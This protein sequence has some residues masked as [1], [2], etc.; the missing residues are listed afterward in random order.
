[1]SDPILFRYADY[2]DYYVSNRDNPQLFRNSPDVVAFVYT[3]KKTD[4]SGLFRLI[5][6]ITPNMNVVRQYIGDFPSYP[7]GVYLI[8]ETAQNPTKRLFWMTP[9]PLLN[10]YKSATTGRIERAEAVVVGNHFTFLLE[11]EG[12]NPVK[13]HKT[14]YY[15]NLDNKGARTQTNGYFKDP[16]YVP[17]QGTATTKLFDVLPD[18]K[19]F[20]L[21]LVRRPFIDQRWIAGAP[22][23][24]KQRSRRIPPVSQ[25]DGPV[26]VR[27]PIVSHTGSILQPPIQFVSGRRMTATPQLFS[28]NIQGAIHPS[29]DALVRVCRRMFGEDL[30]EIRAFGIRQQNGKWRYT[31]FYDV[32][33][34]PADLEAPA[35]SFEAENAGRVT[36]ERKLTERLLSDVRLSGI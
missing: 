18:H 26:S 22:K 1:M 25:I 30:N 31:V 20:L 15:I 8:T 36:F 33:D 14:T 32:S 3:A 9:E 2:Y 35:H 29:R 16:V 34:W 11:K 13:F 23:K 17:R 28:T 7:R 12:R 6:F 27:R 5:D 24:R 10:M 21:D 4:K 19:E